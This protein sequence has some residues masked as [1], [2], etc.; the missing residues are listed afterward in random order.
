M[1]EEI[2]AKKRGKIENE[3]RGWISEIKS[4]LEIK[5]GCQGAETEEVRKQFWFVRQ[6]F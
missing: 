3:N 5:N 2:L 4:V 6:E 1:G